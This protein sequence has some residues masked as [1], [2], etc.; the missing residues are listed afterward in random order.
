MDG[1]EFNVGDRVVSIVNHP[2]DNESIIEGLSGCVCCILDE[3][4]A[5]GDRNIGVCWDEPIDGG[6]D[7]RG[8]CEWRRGWFVYARELEP[9]RTTNF[10]AATD[11]ELLTFL[12]IGGG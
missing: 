9:E 5:C 2:D 4:V 1:Y 12:G 8:N 6:H 11:N 10:D 3:D 7:C